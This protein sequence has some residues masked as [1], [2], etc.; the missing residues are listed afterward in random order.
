M[1]NILLPNKLYFIFSLIIQVTLLITNTALCKVQEYDSQTNHFFL[2]TINT[3]HVVNFPV[4]P[5]NGDDGYILDTYTVDADTDIT[6]LTVTYDPTKETLSFTKSTNEI[7]YD[8]WISESKAYYTYDSGGWVWLMTISTPAAPYHSFIT[9][10]T[11][12]LTPI[13]DP[14][15]DPPVPEP[16]VFS[17]LMCGLAAI[18]YRERKQQLMV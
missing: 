11:P 9:Y 14:P 5:S 15:V 3:Q 10:L 2:G 18:K 8:D 1:K 12:V 13:P 4:N 6:K 17:L 16:S 7:G